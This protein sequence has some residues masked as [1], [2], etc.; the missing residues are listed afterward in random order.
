MRVCR[1]PYGPVGVDEIELLAAVAVE[2]GGIPLR[3]DPVPTHVRNRKIPGVEAADRTGNESQPGHTGGLLAAFEQALQPDA[4]PEEGPVGPQV[5]FERFH[6]AQG[7]QAL[8]GGPEATHAGKDQTF[9]P[10]NILG[11]CDVGKRV[12][13]PAD[14]V[15]QTTHITGAVVDEGDHVDAA[16]RVGKPIF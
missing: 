12:T 2:Q 14:R 13:Q 7:M 1:R 16:R 6:V 10:E 8:H 5:L 4:D 15:A 3:A 11:P 9:G